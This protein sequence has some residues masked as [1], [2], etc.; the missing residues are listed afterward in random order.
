[1]EIGQGDLREKEEEG[2]LVG[3]GGWGLVTSEALVKGEKAFFSNDAGTDLDKIQGFYLSSRQK[4]GSGGGERGDWVGW[5][6]GQLC[7]S[8]ELH[9]DLNPVSLGQ[10]QQTARP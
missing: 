1:V 7:S 10:R 8:T 4:G 5:Y 6:P 9:S 3:K 2:G